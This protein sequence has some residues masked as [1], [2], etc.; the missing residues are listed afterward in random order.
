[1]QSQKGIW[2]ALIAVAIIAVAALGIVLTTGSSSSSPSFGGVTNYDEVDATAI[3]I[4]GA[5]GSRVGPVIAKTCSLISANFTIAASTTV[6]MD[7]VVTGVVSGDLV[8]ADLAT[9]TIQGNGWLIAQSS[10]SSTA[11][12]VTVQITNN[13]GTSKT[14]PASVASTTQ[15]LV[16]HPRSTVPGL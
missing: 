12:F 8:F 4:G 5:S 16:L 13:T 6:A 2:V 10:A 15:V 3:K 11:G 1:M 14:L 9:S 7:C